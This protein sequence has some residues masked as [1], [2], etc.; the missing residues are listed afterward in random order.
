MKKSQK[1]ITVLFNKFAGKEVYAPDALIC[2]PDPVLSEMQELANKN[3][4]NLVA[5]YPRMAMT[6]EINP[7]RIS[8]S[9]DKGTDGK[10]RVGNN[11]RIG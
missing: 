9:I 11:F 1:N 3:G 7:K 5:L 4:L 8:V 2:K 6:R 10:Y